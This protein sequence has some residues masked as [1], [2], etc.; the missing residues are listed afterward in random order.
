M[1]GTTPPYDQYIKRKLIIFF[2]DQKKIQLDSEGAS[3]MS[4]QNAGFFGILILQ[5]LLSG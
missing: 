4:L 2:T 1:M 5:L 3:E